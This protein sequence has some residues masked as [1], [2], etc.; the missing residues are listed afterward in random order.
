M[1]DGLLFEQAESAAIAQTDEASK[2]APEGHRER[3]GRRKLGDPVG[4]RWFQWQCIGTDSVL[5]TGC[6]PSG[7]VYT[8]GPRKGR[9]KYDGD[10]RKV[11]VT[12]AEVE[13]ERRRFADAGKCPE[14]MGTGYLFHSWDHITGTKAKPCH[15]CNDQVATS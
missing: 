2:I 9:I 6:V 8:K 10:E 14:C 13:A 4:F 15:L 7:A 11:V 1:T 5:L 12:D 3:I